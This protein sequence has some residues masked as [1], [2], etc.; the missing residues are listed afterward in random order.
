MGAGSQPGGG[1][2]LSI[3]PPS[4][5]TQ[6]VTTQAKVIKG[7]VGPFEVAGPLDLHWP[8]LHKNLSKLCP[9]GPEAALWGQA[10]RGGQTCWRFL[11]HRAQHTGSCFGGMLS[12]LAS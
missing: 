7:E 5:H 9:V 10:V 3:S 1:S 2:L 12:S 8:L 6:V 4:R 11:Q